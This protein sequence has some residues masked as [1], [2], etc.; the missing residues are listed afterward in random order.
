MNI[1][2]FSLFLFLLSIIFI[3]TGCDRDEFDNE[4]PYAYVDIT[5]NTNNLQYDDLRI[6]GYTYIP[7]GL[8]GIIVLRDDF[9]NH[10]AFERACPFQ[11]ENPCGI[12][13]IEIS[14]FNMIDPCCSS[15]FD[16]Q[17]IPTSG[18]AINRM[19]EYFTFMDGTFLT[20]SSEPF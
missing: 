3:L 13:E 10:K 16:L 6:R 5:I 19:R 8:R 18:P 20:I 1:K 9:G 7:G 4:L 12:I 11:P 2:C 15:T 17:G 14:G